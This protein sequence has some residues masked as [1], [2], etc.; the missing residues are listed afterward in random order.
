MEAHNE[1][2]IIGPSVLV[3]FVVKIVSHDDNFVIFLSIELG[4]NYL[5]SF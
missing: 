5:C 1:G 2:R 3:A 4:Y